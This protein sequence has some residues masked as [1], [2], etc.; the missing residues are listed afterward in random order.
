VKRIISRIE[1]DASLP[2]LDRRFDLVAAH[3]VCFHRLGRRPDGQPEEWTTDNWKFFINDIRT[4]FLEPDGRLLLDFNPRRDG[5][6][7]FTPE[8]RAF[9]LS[10]GA[11]ILR[12]KALL[13][14]DA[15]KRAS[16]KETKKRDRRR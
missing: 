11:R 12:S 14:T 16:F 5:S 7:F 3:R 9:F 15:N 8:L 2:D 1:P 13:A 4:R 10:Q 6:S